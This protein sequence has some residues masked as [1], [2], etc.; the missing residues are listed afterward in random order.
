MINQIGY[1]ITNSQLEQA[2]QSLPAIDFKFTL[3]EP[4]GN[5][6]YDS[7]KIKDKFKNTI[8]EEILLT[9]P[10]DQGE[11]RLISLAPGTCYWAH[12][13]IDDRWHL[14]LVNEHSFLA[15]LSSPS[16]YTTD[17]GKW[18][19]MDTSRIHSAVNF[20]EHNRIQLVVRKLLTNGCFDN[21]ISI[22][23]P[24]PKIDNARYLFDTL[25]SPWLNLT[26]KTGCLKN[27]SYTENEITFKID[28]SV[29]NSLISKGPFTVIRN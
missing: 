28:E 19:I 6:F 4:T 29:S 18:Y 3:N 17:V 8:W 2:I 7:W 20:G 11:A 23:I 25:Y 21:A 22:T 13:D 15:D 9:L 5:F 14:S 24:I 26:N 27:F 16:L 1:S 12:G 10:F